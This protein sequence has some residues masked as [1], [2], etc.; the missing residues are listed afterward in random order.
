MKICDICN[1]EIKKDTKLFSSTQLKK[2]VKAGF[3]PPKDEIDNMAAQQYGKEGLKL[4]EASWIEQV[5]DDNSDWLLCKKCT[6][7]IEK[8]LSKR[9]IFNLFNRK[10]N[11]T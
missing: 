6:I 8:V 10:K 2:A 1:V 7:E 9:S 3:R 11:S 5:M 4:M